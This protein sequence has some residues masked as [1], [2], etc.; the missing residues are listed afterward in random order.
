MALFATLAMRKM[1]LTQKQNENQWKQMQMCQKLQDLT[2]LGTALQDG[3]LT[4]DEIAGLGD[5]DLMGALGISCMMLGNANAYANGV[6]NL[7]DMQKYLAGI[8]QLNQNQFAGLKPEDIQNQFKFGIFQQAIERQN[9]ELEGKIKAEE[10]KL[11]KQKL[12]IEIEGKAIDAELQA[13][14]QGIDKGAKAL[15]PKL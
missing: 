9:R 15:A 12:K 6:I 5:T 8:T 7:P 2:F 11:Q 14:D 1:Q 4:P 3:M 13:L 10:A